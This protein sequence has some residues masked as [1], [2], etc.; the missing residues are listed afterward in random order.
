MSAVKRDTSKK[1][2]SI[3]DGAIQAF[4]DE[5]YEN[6]SMDHIAEI[7]GAS[8]RTVYN[9]FDSKE[10][11]FQAVVQRFMDAAMALKNIPYDPGRSLEDQLTDFA[12]AK[13]SFADNPDWM[14][15]LK[16]TM[17]VF[18]REPELAKQT[19]EKAM[20]G[21]DKLV[22]WLR[23]AHADGAIECPNPEMAA[24]VFWAMVGGAFFWPTAFGETMEPAVATALKDEII[25]TFLSRYRA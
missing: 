5:G 6:T 10:A 25:A 20:C 14:G 23:A 4:R 3:I 21:E 11:L 8:K 16:V 18:M 9:H 15:L 1:R 2:E 12:K 17:G 19:M 7:A 22:L 24:Q 13:M